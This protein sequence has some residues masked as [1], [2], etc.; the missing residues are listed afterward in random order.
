MRSSSTPTS[1]SA[2]TLS[3]NAVPTAQT[4]SAWAGRKWDASAS[5]DQDDDAAPPSLLPPALDAFAADQEDD[6]EASDIIAREA[7]D[8]VSELEDNLDDGWVP[9]V[10]AEAEQSAAEAGL[11]KMGFILG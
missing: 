8:Q 10:L 4:W 1:R 5:D 3:I 11:D 2:A 9:S 7:S 6:V